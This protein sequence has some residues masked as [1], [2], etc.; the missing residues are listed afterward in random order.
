M[1]A[2]RD[3]KHN[4][5]EKLLELGAVITDRDKG[6]RSALHYASSSGSDGIVKLLLSKKAD[7]SLAAGPEEQ[8]PLHMACSRPS[9]AV[10]IVKTLLKAS[11]KD[12]KL[13]SDKSGSIPLYLAVM[14][15]NQQVVKE[16]LGSQA[17][18]QVKI[19]RGASGDTVLHAAVRK[20][21]VDIAKLLVEFGCPVDEQNTEGQTALH[22]AAYEGDEAMIKFLQTTRVDA[23]IAD[24]HDRTPLHLAAQRGHSVVA[25]F[26]VDKLKAN[27]N[28]RTKD[29]STLMHIASQAGHPET[30][31]VF[32]KKGVPLHMPNK[33]GAV[34]LHAA[35]RKGHVGVVRALLSKGASVD[36]K[37]KDQY[38][39]LHIAVKHCKPQVVQI[40]LG[41]GA[42]VQHRGGRAEET[43][44]HIAARI[45]DGEKVAEMLIK[46]GA[47]VNAP[48]DNG[49][50]AVHVAA[51]FGNLKVLKLLINEKADTAKRAKNGESAL[52]HA[53]RAGHYSLL[54]ELVRLLFQVKSK[55]VAKLVINM[56]TDKGETPLHYAAQLSK[57][58]VK[59]NTDIDIV[60]LLLEHGADCTAVTHQSVET[61]IH[62]CA[63]SGN[64]DI[65]IALLKSI[66]PTK[67]QATVNKRSSSGSSPLLVASNKGNVEVVRTLLKYHARVD[68]FDEVPTATI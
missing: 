58:K 40:L 28:L 3:N 36:T 53:I 11:G 21:D 39:A 27:V 67:L 42:N 68:V 20:K 16:L 2:A 57:S 30:T 43:P 24:S 65:L 64:N 15:G 56:P 31:L 33:D 52:H 66:P 59:G 23:N 35:A 44:L 18:Q 63:R 37:T 61:P 48:S 54:E 38:T 8:L 60:K 17:E 12:A 32:L 25:E 51:R 55:A 41:Y 46:S 14:A 9:G 6:G 50:T 26:L 19:T 49:E 62:E 45:K 10:E 4:I 1:L 22:I 5:V 13:T 47:D 29:G 34:C 7:A